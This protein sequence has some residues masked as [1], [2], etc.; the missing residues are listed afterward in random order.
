M[1]DRPREISVTESSASGDKTTSWPDK[2]RPLAHLPTITPSLPLGE[3]L[4]L[5]LEEA[6]INGDLSPGQRLDERG[7][8]TH[9]GVSRIPLREALRALEVGGWIEK[10]RPR[11]GIRVRDIG[12]LEL[13]KLSEV[14]ETLDG[15][16]AALAAER[17]TDEQLETLMAVTK[18]AR[19]ALPEDDRKRVVQL[20]TEFH[21]VLARCSQNEVFEE[22]LSMLDKRIRRFLWLVNRDVLTTSA[23]EHEALV[24]AIARRDAAGARAIARRHAMQHSPPAGADKAPSQFGTETESTFPPAFPSDGGPRREGM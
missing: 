13:A 19:N 18:E 16:C 10:A 20:N 12:P 5:V 2:H 6:I 22:I 8:A 21:R 9:F 15:E 14:R 24:N 17:R 4:Y 1:S 7:L 3:Q 11:Q 23:D